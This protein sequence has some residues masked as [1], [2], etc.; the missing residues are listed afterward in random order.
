VVENKRGRG[1]GGG[2]ERRAKLW[3][4]TII[5]SKNPVQKV[6]IPGMPIQRLFTSPVSTELAS[7]AY[8]Y[9]YLVKKIIN[10]CRTV[11]F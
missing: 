5:S 11:D 8:Q 3:I 4:Q 10:Q 6:F 2:G 1:G 7:Q 9:W